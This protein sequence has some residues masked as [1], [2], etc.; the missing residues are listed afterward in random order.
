MRD[1]VEA[2]D[3]VSHNGEKVI[4]ERANLGES[5]QGEIA[6]TTSVLFGVYVPGIKNGYELLVSKSSKLGS[7]I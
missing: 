2:A 3:C 7:K 4:G 6:K 5:D 1:A